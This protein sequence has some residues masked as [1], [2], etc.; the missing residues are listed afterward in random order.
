MINYKK[1]LE[2]EW[3]KILDDTL[4]KLEEVSQ[5]RSSAQNRLYHAYIS[6]LTKCFSEQ[7]IFISHDDL[8]EWLRQK[9]IKWSYKTNPITWIRMVIRKSTAKLNKK[10]FSTYIKDIEKYIYQTYEITCMLR[11]DTFSF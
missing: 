8:H 6:D 2:N 5:T 3:V 1:N 11:T 4:I 7:G 10:E 9:L